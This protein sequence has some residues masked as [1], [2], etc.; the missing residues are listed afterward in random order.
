[1]P[2]KEYYWKN[3]EKCQKYQKEYGDKQ[4]KAFIAE[5]GIKNDHL[6]LV[7][8]TKWGEV[9]DRYRIHSVTG[10]VYVFKGNWRTKTQYGWNP[11][12]PNLDTRGYP[13]VTI[14]KD[15]QKTSIK[16]HTLVMHTINGTPGRLPKIPAKEWKRYSSY[17]KNFM[18][19]NYWQ[20]N[21]IDHDKT[22]FS[23]SN[24]EWV[25]A[26]ENVKKYQAHRVKSKKVA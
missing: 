15:G 18:M 16:V 12:T 2:D 7:T 6:P 4:Y 9:Y 19:R 5:T 10:M 13:T 17:A 3:K 25:D 23:P 20:V 8:A 11:M 1:V 22:N 21:H 26:E 24:L 14:T